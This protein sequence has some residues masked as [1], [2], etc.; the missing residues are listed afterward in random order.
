MLVVVFGV[1]RFGVKKL[2]DLAGGRCGN[3]EE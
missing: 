1:L 2:G 3:W